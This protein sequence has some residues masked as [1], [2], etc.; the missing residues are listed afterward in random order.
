MKQLLLYT[1][2][3][4]IL[5]GCAGFNYAMK[6]YSGVSVTHY[7]FDAMN[8]RVMDKPDEQ[9]V[10]ITKSISHAFGAGA[11][12]ALTFASSNDVIGPEAEFYEA[13]LSYLRSTGR[14]CKIDRSN[15]VLDGQWEFF[16]TCKTA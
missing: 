11:T 8:W 15:L 4:V 12:K 7:E 13:T 6:N 9:R 1:L 2:I 5:F 10:M 3:S 14:D 16:Y